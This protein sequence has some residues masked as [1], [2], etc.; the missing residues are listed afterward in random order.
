METWGTRHQTVTKLFYSVNRAD[1]EM[2]EPPINPSDIRT[3][4]DASLKLKPFEVITFFVLEPARV[5]G[6]HKEFIWPRF[7]G[8]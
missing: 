7:Y 8:C 6:T 3:L 1:D 2:K 4:K 5:G